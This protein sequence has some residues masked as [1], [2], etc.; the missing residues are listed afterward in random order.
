[1]AAFF[2]I[3][4]ALLKRVF[5]YRQQFLFRFFFYLLNHSKTLSFY[6]CL[7]FWEEEKSAR[8]KFVEYGGWDMITVLVLAKNSRTSINVQARALA[9]RKIHDWFFHNSARFIIFY[10]QKDIFI[11]TIFIYLCTIFSVFRHIIRVY[12]I[13]FDSW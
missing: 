12:A 11:E 8:I 10:I 13:F 1:M 3:L 4:A 9:W 6:G 2:P 5:W 7:Q